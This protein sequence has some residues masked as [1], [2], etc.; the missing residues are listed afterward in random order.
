[1]LLDDDIERCCDKE[2]DL[3]QKSFPLNFLSEVRLGQIWNWKSNF[4]TTGGCA[5]LAVRYIL[6][7]QFSKRDVLPQISFFFLILFLS[8]IWFRT[9]V[10]SECSPSLSFVPPF[11]VLF[12][13]YMGLAV[14]DPSLLIL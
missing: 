4:S 7:Q 3:Q 14:C 2:F 1:M 13:A 8:C 5:R 11:Y 10:F 6:R 12:K 9:L